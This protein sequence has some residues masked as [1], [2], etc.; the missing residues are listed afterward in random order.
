MMMLMQASDGDSGDNAHLQYSLSSLHQ[1]QLGYSQQFSV[2]RFTG[3]VR[4]LSPLDREHAPVIELTVRT[5]HH[6]TRTGNFYTKLS[7]V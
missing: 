6:D 3:D 5:H 4:L 7:P 1:S 2:D